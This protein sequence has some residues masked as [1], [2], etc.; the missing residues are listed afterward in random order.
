[1][2]LPSLKKLSPGKTRIFLARA[3]L[4]FILSIGL[5]AL[6]SAAALAAATVSL[7]STPKL[8]TDE[9]VDRLVQH[10]HFYDSRRN[11]TG[12][13]ANLFSS[14]TIGDDRVVID[15]A[16][17]LVWQQS[18]SAKY[19]DHQGALAYI[20]TLNEERYANCS[21]W[22][23][24]TVEELASL[25]EEKPLT[26]KLHVDPAFAAHQAWCWSSDYRG[27]GFS[28]LVSFYH[29]SIDWKFDCDLVFVRAVTS[30]ALF[31]SR[32][33]AATSYMLPPPTGPTY[34]NS[35]GM[36]FVRIPAGSFI[37]G[38]PES[39]PGR[40]QDEGPQHL[41]KLSHSFYLGATEVTQRQWQEIMGA[42]PS[43]FRGPDLPVENVSWE[44]CQEFIRRLNE[45]EHTH[46]YR[47][48][49]EAEWE[50]ACRAGSSTRFCFGDDMGPG[51]RK[52]PLRFYFGDEGGMLEAYAW[53][54]NIARNRTHPVAQKKPNRWGLFD[55]H[56][57]VA[58]WCADWYG[59][60]KPGQQ[61]DPRGPAQGERRVLRGGGYG[62]GSWSVRSARR[63]AQPPQG[64]F[65]Q[66]GLRLA[67]DAK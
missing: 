47:L 12:S 55:M 61:L 44:D 67:M 14:V 59:P 11:P 49:T 36:K 65:C 10:Y 1:M 63:D 8:L 56:G 9:D 26:G 32:G 53:Y 58:E 24:P 20:Q 6:W 50:Y 25:L 7:R 18:G 57:N 31:E 40:N 64:H 60:Y 15:K 22:R 54:G 48:P 30:A 45:R 29:G 35:I 34:T 17:G 16:T 41:V 23:L 5:L 51:A 4:F 2:I 39:E 13:F 46:R 28:Y 27:Q 62:F 42:N 43:R 19:M 66:W 38:S 33:Q 3:A 21:H 52:D 37:M